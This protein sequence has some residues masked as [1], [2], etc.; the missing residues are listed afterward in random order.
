MIALTILSRVT[1]L[2]P[3]TPAAIIGLVT[4]ALSTAGLP[5]T[6]WAASRRWGTRRFV[7]DIGLSIR[8]IDV[9]L[10]IVGAIVLTITMTVI[11]L[12]TYAIGLPN[13]SNLSDVA[14]QGRSVPLFVSLFVLA[15]V[16][17]PVTEEIMF[18]GL[19]QRGLASRFPGWGAVFIQGT[20]FGAAHYLPSEGW[21]NLTLLVSLAVM[22]VGLGFLA[23]LTGRLGASI[24]AHAAFNCF[25][26]TILWITLG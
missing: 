11:N 14:E 1:E 23:N 24:V 5:L 19:I 22:G 2:L 9:P 26:L 12:I 17:A 20:I 6:A 4:L 15:G 8:W 13:G 10:G 18:R 25:Q 16:I 7:R 3:E 21:G